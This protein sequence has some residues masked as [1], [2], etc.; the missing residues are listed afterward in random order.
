M[1]QRDKLHHAIRAQ[2]AYDHFVY[3][4]RRARRLD[5]TAALLTIG[6]LIGFAALPFI[7]W[8]MEWL[9]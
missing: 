1:N 3:E 8:A 6:A 7:L 5:T 2:A 4:H 9:P